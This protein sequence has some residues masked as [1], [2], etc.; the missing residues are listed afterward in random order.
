[1]IELVK[2]NEV[3]GARIKVIGVGGGGGNAVKTM[4]N[5]TLTGVDFIAANTDVQALTSHVCTNKIQLGRQLTQ[6]LGAGAD[7]DIGREAAMEDTQMLRDALSGADMVFVTA[8][9]GGGT[10]TGAAPVIARIARELGALTVAVVTK[11]FAFEGR[12]RMRQAEEGIHALRDSVDTL[13]TIP[14]Q[15]LLAVSPR[16][17][18]FA[19]SFKMADNVLL[20]AVRGISNL[21]TVPGL[22]NLDFADVRKIMANMGLAMMGSGVASGDNR[23][24]DAA[25]RAISSP[26]LD[27]V[28]IH[29]ARG[30]LINITGGA[31]FTI[32]EASD[33]A[34]LIAEEVDEDANIIFGAVID[35][36]MG[37]EIC[38]TVIATGFGE[39]A[40]KSPRGT[41]RFEAERASMAPP[42]RSYTERPTF[43][44]PAYERSTY[45]RP[46]FERAPVERPIVERAPREAR[47]SALDRIPRDAENPRPVVR[48][49][50]VVDGEEPTWRRTQ[51]TEA[52]R[53]P[54]DDA[55]HH[56]LSDEAEDSYEIPAFLR[57]SAV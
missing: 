34:T 2:Q 54:E 1:M 15:R 51:L 38:I 55:G 45:E 40:A 17:T 8:G 21:I 33:A 7:P 56:L 32:H 50:T 6:G 43:E 48:L 12:K 19:D 37:D 35:E 29:G 27:D 5:S 3:L 23:A 10:G 9:M 4:M 25:K 24:V 26:L 16:D 46:A 39:A 42:A 49:G 13:I 31:S 30:V 52:V 44:A 18:S 22:I 20:D 47:P 28:S 14:N 36:N 41:S 11:P 53:T 57:K